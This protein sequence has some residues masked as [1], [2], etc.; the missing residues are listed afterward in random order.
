MH[1]SGA[2]VLLLSLATCGAHDEDCA[3]L[4]GKTFREDGGAPCPLDPAM[5]CYESISFEEGTYTYNHDDYS[6]YGEYACEDG[7]ID[8]TAPSMPAIG[9]IEAATGKLTWKGKSF[10]VLP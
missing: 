10:T 2:L 8:E 6:S 1:R 5:T 3:F 4:P 7:T 9:T